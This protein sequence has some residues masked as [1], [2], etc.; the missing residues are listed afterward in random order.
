MVRLTEIRL[1][2][3]PVDHRKFQCRAKNEEDGQ[4]S[5]HTKQLLSWPRLDDALQSAADVRH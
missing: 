4:K 3:R 5:V 1:S 2:D